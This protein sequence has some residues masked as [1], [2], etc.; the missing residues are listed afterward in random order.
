MQPDKLDQS[1]VN[2]TKAIRQTESGG[3]FDAKGGSGEFGGYQYTPD[4]WN[5][6]SK[7]Y[8]VNVT[9]D[10]ATR[11]QQ[12]EVTYKRIKEWKD[13]G[14]NVGQIAS[15]WNAGEGKP[16]AYKEDWRGVNK[17]GVAYDTPAY[18]EKVALAYQK[19]KGAGAKT[20]NAQGIEQVDPTLPARPEKTNYGA[21]AKDIV[22]DPIK[23]LLAKPAARFAEAVGR[24]GV[25][26]KNIKTGY[27]AMSD[28]GKGQ[29]IF[30]MNIEKQKGFDQGGGKQI[31]GDALK[32]ASYLYGGG[33]AASVVGGGVMQ[34]VKQGAKIGA[35]GGATYGAGEEMQKTESTLGSIAKA[36]AVGG[37]IGTVAGGALG[38][39]TQGIVG[40]VA[41]RAARRQAKVEN[42]VNRLIRGTPDDVAKAR[43]V[44]SELD[45]E[46]VQSGSDLAERVREKI[47]TL[48]NKA[49]EVFA[50]N[51]AAKKLNK[52]TV[53]TEVNGQKVVHN[54]V[55]D[56]LD[57]LEKFYKK[58]ND[59]ES[60]ALIAQLRKQ[61]NSVGL[62]SKAINDIARLHGKDLN[63][64]NANGKLASGL[65]RQ[66]AE[67][68][69]KGVKTTSRELFGDDI[70]KEIDGNIAT[71]IRVEGLIKKMVLE[72]NKLESKIKSPS[73]G[74]TLH[75]IGAEVLDF[76][77]FGM[78]RGIAKQLAPRGVSKTLNAIDWEKQIAENLK[79]IVEANKATD[80]AT[81]IRKLEEFLRKAK[82]ESKKT[83]VKKPVAKKAKKP[84]AKKKITKTPKVEKK[85]VDKNN[86][87]L[88]PQEG[89]VFYHASDPKNI[90][91]IH[92]TGIDTSLNTK[93]FAEASDAFYVSDL[94]TSEMYGKDFVG[95]RVKPNE[96][97]KTLGTNTK[98]WHDNVGIA[99]SSIEA[100]L[101]RQKIKEIG[102][103]VINHGNE[104]E[105]L[106]T[107]KFEVVPKPKGI[108]KPAT[109]KKTVKK[110][111]AKKKVNTEDK[112]FAKHIEDWT[113]GRIDDHDDSIALFTRIAKEKGYLPKK[114]VTLY[115]GAKSGKELTSKRTS[116]WTYD[117]TAAE[118]FAKMSDGQVVSRTFKPSEIV[119]DFT[120]IPGDVSRKLGMIPEESEVIVKAIGVKKPR[121]NNLAT[122]A[123]RFKTAD[124]FVKA[125]S[126]LYHRTDSDIS[127]FNV[128]KSTKNGIWGDG[129]Y[130]NST[131]DKKQYGNKIVEATLEPNTKLLEFDSA[132]DKKLL[133]GQSRDDWAKI[134][135]DAGYDGAVLDRKDGTQAVVIF[136]DNVIK[137]NKGLKKPGLNKP[138][139]NK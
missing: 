1:V 42:A 67:R 125:R 37:A 80:E 16:N 72:V 35:I 83:K 74:A 43:K 107:S 60:Q 131:P 26:G 127:K 19:I 97:V 47:V 52:L 20:A 7:K 30:G 28:E 65:N 101:G 75:K 8:G 79:L 63:A 117:E 34:G 85:I 112:V 90:K 10:K 81:I 46:G 119:I 99:E 24:T 121:S 86:S 2:L 77:S 126:T 3:N 5:G 78:A 44:I 76:A 104:L 94:R 110:P 54:Y 49:D 109:K 96:K 9:L 115:R 129:I 130:F 27:E 114:P 62:D 88:D 57:Q 17:F 25:L 120:E 106:N 73:F 59:P 22:M 122:E 66:A 64:Y 133:K 102:F 31:A 32:S 39:A 38:G 68:T 123:K 58:V 93:G 18:A 113:T 89:M 105:I 48:S 98:I 70:A 100:K 40:A 139:S 111:V 15:M 6:A 69:R 71:L 55:E 118:E 91:S 41:Q 108:K 135:R 21:I 11:Q 136:N 84:T 13:G 92:E 138:R 45:V 12:N 33:K 132:L 87:L 14:K 50:T 128:S 103:D 82:L 124:E 53:T 4:T 29:D 36:T 23:V 137:I 61:A 56:S 51:K 134:V 116:S 95:V